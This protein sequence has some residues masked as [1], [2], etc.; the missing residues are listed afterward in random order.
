[1]T[2]TRDARA[3]GIEAEMARIAEQQLPFEQAF[4]E[5]TCII[6]VPGRRYNGPGI[7]EEVAR[8]I[9]GHIYREL[10]NP[11]PTIT[12]VD[13][14]RL[15]HERYDRIRGWRD[16]IDAGKGNVYVGKLALNYGL[17]AYNALLGGTRGFH[18]PLRHQV[19]HAELHSGASYARVIVAGA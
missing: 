7:D 13:V 15:R 5:M 19:E 12:Q 1:M 4:A 10:T 14:E 11:N 18:F 6:G 8:V 16:D 3:N 9:G 17:S 2:T